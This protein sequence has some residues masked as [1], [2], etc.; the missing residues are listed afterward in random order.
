MAADRHRILQ[1]L[2]DAPRRW[3]VNPVRAI[4]VLNLLVACMG[5]VLTAYHLHDE[6]RSLVDKV[7]LRAQALAES[8]ALMIGEQLRQYELLI[9]Q[10]EVRLNIAAALEPGAGPDAH[11]HTGGVAQDVLRQF[12]NLM[13]YG[14]DLLLVDA[15]GHATRA[16]DAITASEP[17][18]AYCPAL[19]PLRHT[20]EASRIVTVPG[21]AT[22]HC[23][24]PG[25]LV[26]QHTLRTGSGAGQAQL[27]LLF[28]PLSFGKLMERE[29]G[30]ITPASRYQV[31]GH[32][33]ALLLTGGATTHPSEALEFPPLQHPHEQASTLRWTR[34]LPGSGTTLLGADSHVTG[35]DIHARVL[36]VLEEALANEW[37]AYLQFW[38]LVIGLF[39]T[40]WTAASVSVIRLIRRYEQTLQQAVDRFE[41]SLDYANVGHWAWDLA[42]NR[43]TFNQ[44]ALHMLALDRTPD[45]VSSEQVWQR[46]H[47]DD[48]AQVQVAIRD[49]LEHNHVYDTTF[50]VRGPDGRVRWVH[51]RGN[52]VRD[53]DQRAVRM[54]GVSQDISERKQVE[55]NMLH[56][57]R[58]LAGVLD[59]AMDAIISIDELHRIVLF[60][61]AAENMFGYPEEQ[62]LGQPL[63]RLI[64]ARFRP[65]HEGHI[66]DYAASQRT[67]RSMGGFS[68]L[69]AMRA[70]R[71]GGR[72]YEVEAAL[73]FVYRSH[74]AVAAY[75]REACALGDTASVTVT[76]ADAPS[77][78]VTLK[79]G[80][81]S[82]T[83]R[84]AREKV[85]VKVVE[86]VSCIFPLKSLG[87]SGATD[88][89]WRV[90]SETSSIRSEI[91]RS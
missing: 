51:A 34:P 16:T 72:E 70:T 9:N 69:A 82:V 71:A 90:H 35:L 37:P 54:L 24:A 59:S 64:P 77:K 4:I 42:S 18:A 25:T 85:T 49:S 63:D 89:G 21:P 74:D 47:P 43:I 84:Y 32:D 30:S 76:S 27:W 10:L 8:Q 7:G 80:D 79:S 45:T 19:A 88:A 2:L 66:R 44:Q 83:A 5:I 13:P 58:Q 11:P 91:E 50:R 26:F 53:A 52:F 14:V 67:A 62:M 60:N 15:R 3:V 87:V 31:I 56:G 81:K 86:D 65:H 33:H 12:L 39:L 68:Q 57:Q 40:F 6:Y 78:P 22:G 41:T 23:P 17:L 73:Q 20:T 48:T 36:L 29:L 1:R 61:T 55:L 28:D 75:V 46:I 38:G